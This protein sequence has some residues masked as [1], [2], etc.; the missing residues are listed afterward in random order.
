MGWPRAGNRRAWPRTREPVGIARHQRGEPGADREALLRQP[1][2]VVE[3]PGQSAR[4]Q[5]SCASAISAG[6]P[7]TPTERPPTTASKNPSGWP[8]GILEKPRRGGERRGLAPVERGDLAR[9]PVMPDEERAAAEARALR[10]HQPQHRLRRDHRIRRGAAL[11]E[12][13][14]PRP[15]PPA[16][17]RRRSSSHRPAPGGPPPWPLP[18]RQ[19][20]RHL[21]RPGA[22]PLGRDRIGGLLRGRGQGKAENQCK[23]A[24]HSRLPYSGSVRHSVTL[25]PPC[26]TGGPGGKNG[27]PVDFASPPS[28]VT[29]P[30]RQPRISRRSTS[31]RL[32]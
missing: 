21:Q 10:L 25:S 8:C 28:L 18:R 13:L 17:A 1:D 4:P 24:A 7:G 12:H 2:R 26:A 23:T 30:T 14:R 27:S 22:P 16:D 19:H 5:R 9:G 11:G 29:S 20:R 3:S 32:P 15:R 6:V 31:P